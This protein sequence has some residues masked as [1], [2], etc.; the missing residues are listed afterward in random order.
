M[1]KGGGGGGGVGTRETRENNRPK[2]EK[3]LRKQRRFPSS[4]A[5]SRGKE[6]VHP[7]RFQKRESKERGLEKSAGIR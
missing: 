5:T 4:A 1:E 7:W 3:K 6:K 2:K